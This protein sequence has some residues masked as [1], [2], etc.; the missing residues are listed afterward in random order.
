[1]SLIHVVR[2]GNTINPQAQGFWVRFPGWANNI[3]MVETDRPV[4]HPCV[5]CGIVL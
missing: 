3:C 5:I 4:S 1:M 2:L